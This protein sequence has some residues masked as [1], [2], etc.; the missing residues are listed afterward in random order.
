MAAHG[1]KILVPLLPKAGISPSSNGRERMAAP[2]ACILVL[3]LK[4][5]ICPSSNGRE[6]MGVT[7]TALLVLLLLKV[8]ISPYSNGRENLYV[9][10]IGLQTQ[11][12]KKYV[13]HQGCSK[14][15]KEY[16]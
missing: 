4:V 3:L 11:Q 12:P 16:S 5:G 9:S 8:D 15:T 14:T 1:I 6:R 7:G 2:G 10:A 13:I